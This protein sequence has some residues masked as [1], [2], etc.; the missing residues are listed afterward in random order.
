MFATLLWANAILFQATAGGRLGSGD[1][2]AQ[3]GHT[4]QD[5]R[6]H[7]FHHVRVVGRHHDRPGV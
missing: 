6:R 7:S 1:H 4:R 5:R 3:H 2:V